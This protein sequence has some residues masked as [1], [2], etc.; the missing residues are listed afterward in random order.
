V[1][2]AS[3]VLLVPVALAAHALGV[4]LRVERF[5][6]ELYDDDY[7]YADGPQHARPTAMIADDDGPKVQ[8]A[9]FGA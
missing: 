2:A 3:I 9:F 6:G 7:D 5:A 4:Y 8:R 1:L